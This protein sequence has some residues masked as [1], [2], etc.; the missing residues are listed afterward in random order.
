M[1]GRDLF[2]FFVAFL[3]AN[4]FRLSVSEYLPLPE[5]LMASV[6]K[7][8]KLFKFIH[9]YVFGSPKDLAPSEISSDL[10]EISS[11][12]VEISSELVEISS[13]LVCTKLELL[14]ISAFRNVTRFASA[15]PVPLPIQRLSQLLR[16]SFVRKYVK[17]FASSITNGVF[18]LL[19]GAGFITRSLR[20]HTLYLSSE[21]LHVF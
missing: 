17:G 5:M 14:I 9:L 2:V 3:S 20:V 10:V 6:L 11:A 13:E 15:T 7:R 4:Y 21:L 18:Q 12:I 8:W 16:F 1:E 19:Q